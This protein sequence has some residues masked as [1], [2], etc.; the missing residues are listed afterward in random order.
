[1]DSIFSTVLSIFQN[2]PIIV[3]VI[4]GYI[5]FSFLKS[6]KNDEA[7]EHTDST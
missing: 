5:V 7:N 6:S 1:M 4:V 2:N 3:L